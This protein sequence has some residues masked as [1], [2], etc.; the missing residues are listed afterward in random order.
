MPSTIESIPGLT[1]AVS[2]GA[3]PTNSK[4]NFV[5]V[6]SSII[7][8]LGIRAILTGIGWIVTC[9]QQVRVYPLHLIGSTLVFLLLIQGWWGTFSKRLLADWH[10][11]PFLVFLTTPILYYLVAELLFPSRKP[12][13]MDFREHYWDNF[14][15]FYGISAVIQ[16]NNILMD[17]L[18]PTD[19]PAATATA[20]RLSAFLLL[21][22]MAGV[23]SERIHYLT[24]LVLST[25]F[26]T[27]IWIYN[28]KI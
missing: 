6:L 26:L 27:F 1:T 2:I 16:L 14:R 22:I 17:R 28:T 12:P 19:G 3:V 7:T 20:I 15:W 24:Y 21:T 18:M 11:G 10:F 23:R 5:V 4:F 9:R 13:A 8:A 25:L